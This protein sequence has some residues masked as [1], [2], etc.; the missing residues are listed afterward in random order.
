MNF[1][2]DDA[3]EDVS[4]VVPTNQL[5]TRNDLII[6]PPFSAVTS[7][8]GDSANFTLTP[9]AEKLARQEAFVHNEE[10]FQQSVN[11]ATVNAAIY[12]NPLD[13]T[14]EPP[15]PRYGVDSLAR[16]MFPPNCIVS[17][18]GEPETR[19][20]LLLQTIIGEHYGIMVQL[21][22]PPRA[23]KSRLK[24]MGLPHQSSARYCFPTSQ[25]A[26]KEYVRLWQDI[27]PTIIGFDSF[28]P[29]ISLWG[30]DNNSDTD[31]QRLFTEVF[32]PLRNAGHCVVFLDHVPKIA[33]NVG[34]A[35][36]SQNKKSQCDISMRVEKRSKNNEYSLYVVKDR[37][38][39]YYGRLANT[40]G[41]YGD[42]ELHSEK[43]QIIVECGP[44]KINSQKAKD[45][46]KR[47]DVLRHLEEQGSMKKDDL[48]SLIK[49][50]KEKYNKLLEEL[51]SE[52]LITIN[53]NGGFTEEGMKF[54]ILI[55]LKTD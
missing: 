40:Q 15:Q 26:V 51:E 27:E 11:D 39:I 20:S 28:T 4:P 31:T 9:K 53:R 43:L 50:N 7:G 1:P 6:E 18:F 23:L 41:Y 29:L 24:Q 32:F 34:F 16:P 22:S 55:S 49:G 19:K 13:I 17:I 3:N 21:E 35:T 45:T 10:A 52:S 44:A 30:G 38:N 5:E 8:W 54:K 36:G 33:R 25:R 12:I 37:E 48:Y 46:S 42:L 14:G 47:D 2:M